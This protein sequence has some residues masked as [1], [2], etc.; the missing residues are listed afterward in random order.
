MCYNTQ[1]GYSLRFSNPVLF[2]QFMEYRGKS[3]IYNFLK[4]PIEVVDMFPNRCIL[5][6]NCYHH[7]RT[8]LFKKN[9]RVAILLLVV[10][11]CH[12]VALSQ[13]LSAAALKNELS[14]SGSAKA[15]AD[16]C[17][18]L[19]MKYAEGLKIDSATYYVNRLN[20]LSLQNNYRIGIG[21]YYLALANILHYRSNSSEAKKNLSEAITIFREQKEF[22]LLGMAYSYMAWQEDITGETE[23]AKNHFRQ[24]IHLLSSPGNET[25][26]YRAYFLLSRSY[27]RISAY[28]SAASYYF[29]A[30][31]LAEKLKDPFK[32]YYSSM[33]LGES[34]LSLQN[35]QK[36]RHYLE[37][38]LKNSKAGVNKV[39]LWMYMAKYATCLTLLHDFESAESAINEFEKLTK[40][41]NHTWGW[42]MLDNLKGTLQYQKGNY[43]GAL[44]FLTNAYLK[45][46]LPNG[47]E[48]DPTNLKDIVLNLGRTEFKLK[49]YDSAIVHLRYAEQIADSL[50]SMVDVIETDFLLSLS[51]ERKSMPDS[52]LHYFRRYI[53]LKESVLS[54]EKQKIILDITARYET[55]KKEQAIKILEKE[56]EANTYLLQLQSRQL[57]KQQLEDEKK[58]QQLV[59]I[60]KQNEINKLDA[61]QKTL[62][63]DNEK[64]EN[65]K[66]QAK[67]K[68][69]EKETAYQKLYVLKQKQQKKI[70][71]VCIGAILIV[72]GYG[73]YRYTRR[74]KLQNQQV[75]LN[76]RLRIS[77]ELH[78]ELGSTLSG[79]AMYSHLTREQIKTGKTQEV[80]KS[81]NN[82]QQTAGSMVDKLKDIVWLVNPEQDSLLK[83]M[84]RL[85]DYGEEMAMLKNTEIK[86]SIPAKV[87]AINLPVES[88]RNIYLFCKEALNNAVKYS[89]AGLIELMM[90]EL[91]HKKIELSISD[92]GKGFDTTAVKKGNGLV[93]MQ[94]RA[95]DVNGV[96]LLISSPGH[97]T[98]VSLVCKIT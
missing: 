56:T 16:I 79:I 37:Y 34:F 78:D 18:T 13:S 8:M 66:N 20:E 50:K 69:L 11:T 87:S 60:S 42:M 54:M 40:Q 84:E 64:K 46:N 47:T 38:G 58:S 27:Y 97:G 62:G 51:F 80:E 9:Y 43:S 44:Y 68:L 48:R 15:K 17:F 75:V 4:S 6:G 23:S 61:A 21:K 89:D 39:G 95:A 45:Y 77:R 98:T 86:I 5:Y 7:F 29:K 76:E 72:S 74:R 49:H 91:D 67:L 3:V 93:N 25:E 32:I 2:Y 30:L 90:K 36:A 81:L 33:A 19:S 59:L 96:F 83:L 70:V 22:S 71:Y 94:Q 52:A 88:R 53:V 12:F 14:N 55:G 73:F 41:F 31:M 26:L 1:K 92:N 35:L 63:L 28:D 65:E 82:M 57:E 85:E 24:S 10:I